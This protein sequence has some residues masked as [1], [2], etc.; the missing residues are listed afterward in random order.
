MTTANSVDNGLSGSTGTGSFVG[1]TSPTFTTGITFT[2]TTGGIV[3]T[4]TNDNVA[5]LKVGE[6]I[7]SNI[8]SPGVTLSTG[9]AADITSISLTPGDWDVW[10]NIVNG[11]A[12]GTTATQLIA[13]ISTTSATLPTAPNN[14]AE[15]L[16]TQAFAAGATQ[17]YP[18]GQIRLSLAIT[19]SVFLSIQQSFA[20]A[21]M[22]AYGF[23]GARRRR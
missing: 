17:A 8:T 16:I 23:I 19:T 22:T 14:G 3:G 5:A 4:T 15:I 20:V 18:V 11:P 6:Y 1:S 7:F 9:T 13:W 10:G 21:G 12:G 2:P